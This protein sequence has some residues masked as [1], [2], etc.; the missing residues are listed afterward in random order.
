M[1]ATP[2]SLLSLLDLLSCQDGRP[3]GL[4]SEV[5]LGGDAGP[6]PAECR[7][8]LWLFVFNRVYE[9]PK[10][11]PTAGK[12]RLVT[13]LPRDRSRILRHDV[14]PHGSLLAYLGLLCGFIAPWRFF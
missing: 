12:H 4:L 10:V 7:K 5:L 14:L 13:D 9:A 2:C 3:Y 11:A 8:R 6:L 1:F